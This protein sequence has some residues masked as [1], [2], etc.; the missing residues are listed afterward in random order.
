MNDT[1]L[2]AWARLI[3][4]CDRKVALA[5]LPDAEVA[6]RLLHLVWSNLPMHTVESDLLEE[7]LDRLRRPRH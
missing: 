5:Q 2:A 7:A 6:D 4:S 3:D 1:A